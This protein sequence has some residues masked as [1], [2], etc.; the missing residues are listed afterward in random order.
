MALNRYTIYNAAFKLLREN[1]SKPTRNEVHK[2]LGGAGSKSTI[3]RY[4]HEWEIEHQAAIRAFDDV[5]GPLPDSLMSLVITI[6]EES[7]RAA[8]EIVTEGEQKAEGVATQARDELEEAK[9]EF[10]LERDQLERSI[11]A[12]T[13]RLDAAEGKYTAAQAT[14]DSL[15]AD[16]DQW[17]SQ[18]HTEQRRVERLSEGYQ[19]TAVELER[20]KG[21]STAALSACHRTIEKLTEENR[22]YKKDLESR[23]PFTRHTRRTERPSKKR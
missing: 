6:Y 8:G 5:Q 12:L 10:Q 15:K 14:I 19:A 7:C 21:E 2:A 18:A 13:A 16:V 22:R 20:V 3:Q 1:H 11:D 4:M 17:R 23:Y 9:K